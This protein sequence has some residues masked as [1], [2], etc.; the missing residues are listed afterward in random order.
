MI[1]L[2]V[3]L[4]TFQN[5][6][7]S[8]VHRKK[9]QTEKHDLYLSRISSGVDTIEALDF[10]PIEND[11]ENLADWNLS[12]PAIENDLEKSRLAWRCL[13]RLKLLDEFKVPLDTLA[14]FFN[15][16]RAGYIKNKNPF[17][18]YDHALQGTSHWC[19]FC[20]I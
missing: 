12:I 18:N 5:L 15:D 13:D 8:P 14:N 7:E 9:P 1:E 10:I 2:M 17:H 19:T 20:C 16:V 6:D 3:K 11:L 4:N